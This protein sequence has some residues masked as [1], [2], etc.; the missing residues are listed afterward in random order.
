MPEDTPTEKVMELQKLGKTN[1]EIIQSLQTDGYSFQQ[2]SEALNQ[3]QAKI[4]VEATPAGEA[5]SKAPATGNAPG[6]QPSVIY[7]GDEAE[8]A[9]G[10]A[11][12]PATG[13]A[14]APAPSPEAEVAAPMVEESYSPQTWPEQQSFGYPTPALGSTTED[15]E[16]IAESII[17]EKWRKMIEEMGDVNAW[18]EKTSNDLDAVKQEIMRIENRFENLQNSVIGRIKEYDQA[19]SDV[20]IEMKALGKLLSNIVTPLTENVKKLERIVR[21]IKS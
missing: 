15:I 20:G 10:K 5:T 11:L 18:K 9:P 19:V 21:D 8:K 6:M 16:E 13:T 1:T 4:S 12:P 2:I 3:A 17:A 7:S 14:P